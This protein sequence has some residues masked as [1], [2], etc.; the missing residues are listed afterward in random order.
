MALKLK[1]NFDSSNPYPTFKV[2]PSPFSP[3]L[4]S[5][6]S[7]KALPIVK[8]HLKLLSQ[9]PSLLPPKV[10]NPPLVVKV[11]PIPQIIENKVNLKVNNHRDIEKSDL[12]FIF[13]DFIIILKV[14]F[15]FL[16]TFNII[17]L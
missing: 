6:T 1:S 7:S 11:P 16:F 17:S 2:T 10:T 14:I 3:N 8:P 5:S 13:L 4:S 12:F 9:S 15:F